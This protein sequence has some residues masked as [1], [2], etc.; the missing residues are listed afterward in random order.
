MSKFL[1]NCWC[2]SLLATVAFFAVTG[3]NSLASD[4]PKQALINYMTDVHRLVMPASD[5]LIA[6]APCGENSRNGNSNLRLEVNV[7]NSGLDSPRKSLHLSLT[8]F[9]GSSEGAFVYVAADR[10]KAAFL[11]FNKDNTYELVVSDRFSKTHKIK[12]VTLLLMPG[13]QLVP[14]ARA[15]VCFVAK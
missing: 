1:K 6:E 12:L 14:I 10:E 9:D 4:S 13:G 5:V 7:I 2:A 11:G 3:G 15:V 8:G